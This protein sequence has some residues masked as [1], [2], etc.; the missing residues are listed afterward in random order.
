M[1]RKADALTWP[2]VAVLV[3]A[4]S[5]LAWGHACA[6]G[7]ADTPSS[8]AAGY[9]RSADGFDLAANT[10]LEHRRV[11][12]FDLDAVLARKGRYKPFQ[13]ARAGYFD[14]AWP[15]EHTDLWRSHAVLDAGLPARFDPRHLAASSVRLNLPTWGYTR[16]D[17]EIFIVGGS[18]VALN[19]FTQA[20]KKGAPLTKEELLESIEE[21]LQNPST[22]YIA[23]IRPQ[24]M[25]LDKILYLN[26]GRTINYTGGLLMHQNGFI[27][28]VAQSVLYKI[29]P[30][31]MNIVRSVHLPLV[32]E[33]PTEKLET[34]YNG[35]QVLA[36]GKIVLKGINLFDNSMPGWLLLV[37]PDDLRIDV[38][39]RKTV[40][41]ARLTIDQREDGKAWLYHVNAT[42]S[43]R[44][45]ITRDAFVLDELWTR[46]YRVDGD[47]TTQA[48]SPLLFGEIGQ[49]V[50]ADNTVADPSQ[51]IHLYAQA[52]DGP[53]P[54]GALPRT[55]AFAEDVPGFNFFMVAADP[56]VQQMVVYYDPINNLL[57]AHDVGEDGTL[58]R[59]WE[60]DGYKVSASPAIAPD[61]DLLYI[62]DYAGDRDEFVILRLSTGE[63]V[64]RV[65]LDAS[66]PTI[67]TIFLGTN[68]DVF[69]ISSETGTP[70]G[71]VTRIHLKRRGWPA[72]RP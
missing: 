29:H 11:A 3:I 66:L 58:T 46:P 28:A 5:L 37:D 4:A 31:F 25:W 47:G 32:G 1:I 12:D 10:W 72:W 21:D 9:V 45:E 62:D 38:K 48:S 55:P 63:E 49:V 42:Q 59:R 39:D 7:R 16:R 43:L 54:P 30:Y 24:A 68:D 18:P 27:Y 52:T 17:N 44:F 26:R 67:G 61:R 51:R 71:L 50:F 40:A 34:T 57:S 69:I 60:H 19:S 41:T 22:P 20:I 65:R 23:R 13:P 33:T 56:F 36:S 2:M 70:N 35:M 14:T 15:S 64:A 53:A 6:G 8:T